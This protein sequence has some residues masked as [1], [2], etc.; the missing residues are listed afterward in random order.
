MTKNTERKKELYPNKQSI[1]N[2]LLTKTSLTNN[3]WPL[4]FLSIVVYSGLSVI[5]VL[6]IIFVF[7]IIH[8]FIPGVSLPKLSD[9]ATTAST[10]IQATFAAAVVFGASMA[11]VAYASRAEKIAER[12]KKAQVMM[13][14][15]V[16]IQAVASAVEIVKKYA[17]LEIIEIN[18]VVFSAIKIS[19]LSEY[20]TTI[21][22]S[23]L[24]HLEKIKNKPIDDNEIDSLASIS[25]KEIAPSI[26][27][28]MSL[29]LDISNDV[30]R[31]INLPV[32]GNI[33]VERICDK[34]LIEK[35][36][37]KTK[38]DKALY[39]LFNNHITEDDDIQS[40]PNIDSVIKNKFRELISILVNDLS[41]SINNN[42][43]EEQ[44]KI[45]LKILL[46]KDK[47]GD[48]MNIVSEQ[49]C[50]ILSNDG[51]SLIMSIIA[52]Y[53]RYSSYITHD[54]YIKFIDIA[55]DSINIGY[56]K[57][58]K[59]ET[60]DMAREIGRHLIDVYIPRE[61]EERN[62]EFLGFICG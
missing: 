5:F 39:L 49:I 37:S 18:R 43:L 59:S 12:Q 7:V 53:Y 8:N 24:K 32:S 30:M 36:K 34:Y 47:F 55:A 46:S 6:S 4:F 31:I 13:S 16:G 25:A 14:S 40:S 20:P 22:T 41:R 54:A 1:I 50:K 15:I 21:T 38:E 44:I 2:N 3:P 29:V 51:Y 28:A 57:S 26:R 27:E 60:G 56:E 11:V 62:P 61:P 45:L 9:A 52:N 58:F 19:Q 33:A 42:V 10:I 17:D 23:I 35:I 48:Y